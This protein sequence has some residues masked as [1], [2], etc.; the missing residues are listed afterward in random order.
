MG[1]FVTI[2]EAYSLMGLLGLTAPDDM[3]KDR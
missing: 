2:A 1:R 3:V